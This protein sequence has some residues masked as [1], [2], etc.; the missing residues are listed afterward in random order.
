MNAAE[1][2]IK[3]LDLRR[4]DTAMVFYGQQEVTY[5]ELY[6]G[7]GRFQAAF[8]AHGLKTGDS[9]FFMIGLSP[10]F[11][12]AVLAAMAYGLKILMI[13]PWM[14]RNHMKKIL[15]REKPS[16]FIHA[17]S[18]KIWGMLHSSVRKI[19]HWINIG[20]VKRQKNGQVSLTSLDRNFKSMVA[21]TTGTTGVPKS[22]VR[23]NE[24]LYEQANVYAKYLVSSDSGWDLTLFP[25]F[26]LGNL[27]A[28]KTSVIV[29][30]NWSKKVLRKIGKNY[31]QVSSVTCAPAFLGHIRSEKVYSSL[32][33]VHVGGAPCDLD[34]IESLQSAGK[35]VHVVYGSSEAEPVSLCDGQKCVEF[36]QERGFFQTSFLGKPV[37]EISFEIKEGSFW[38]TGNHV[39]K[40]Y[41]GT[42][43]DQN[44]RTSSDGRIW[45][46]MGD[47]IEEDKD[48]LWY[49]GRS[50][51]SKEAYI[52]EQSVYKRLGSSNAF[53]AVEDGIKVLVC[54]N[55]LRSHPEITRLKAEYDTVVFGKIVR[56]RRHRSR[57]DRRATLRRVLR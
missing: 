3:N 47:A 39:S 46:D 43:P 14:P 57:I 53:M 10:D 25:S 23:E 42:S 49:M 1:M 51:T 35:Q 5:Q 50:G 40:Y 31:P 55:E 45:H 54:G 41:E 34:L 28:G 24:F 6:E 11:Y 12:M 15:E 30:P 18:G 26:A 13:E 4:D 16:L 52:E 36:S 29:P 48:G 56:D 33:H 9:V 17:M 32:S 21:F 2:F 37:S 27:A 19:P 38:V 8:K 20:E 22:V 7:A 44:K